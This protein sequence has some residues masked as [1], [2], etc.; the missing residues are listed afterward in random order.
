MAREQQ[1]GQPSELGKLPNGTYPVLDQNSPHTHGDAVD[2]HDSNR[3]DSENGEYGS[4]GIFRVESFKGPDGKTHEGVGV[5]AGR[6]DRPDGAGRKGPDHATQG[7]I[8]TCD[9]AI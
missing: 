2:T 9:A 5:H 8:R 3:Q 1:R 6:E 4:G 7:C